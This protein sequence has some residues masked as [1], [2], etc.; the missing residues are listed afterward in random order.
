[1]KYV[2]S[3]SLPTHL[4]IF[5]LLFY[6]FFFFKKKLLLKFC[7]FFD[8]KKISYFPPSLTYLSLGLDC[9]L[10]E[11]DLSLLPPSLTH[12]T[13]F[14]ESQLPSVPLPPLLTHLELKNCLGANDLCILKTTGEV[15]S[16]LTL[17]LLPTTFPHCFNFR[18]S[19]LDLMPPL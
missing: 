13:I 4:T 1:M 14:S 19:P 17:N 16:F 10:D 5:P 11:I 8:P 18:P 7:H 9:I 12:L 15:V 3:S 6:S 2:F